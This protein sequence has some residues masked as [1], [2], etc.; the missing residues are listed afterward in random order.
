MDSRK[1]SF[2]Q[3]IVGED[4]AGAL[5][6]ATAQSPD[7]EWAILPRVV[8]AWLEVVS[9]GDFDGFLPGIDDTRLSFKKSENEFSGCINIDGDAYTFRDAS[10]YHIAGSVAVALGSD[11]EHAPPL[12]SPALSKFGKTVDLLVKAR[13]LRKAQ[14]RKGGAGGNAQGPGPAAAP[15]PSDGPA[16]PIPEAPK[17]SGPAVGTKAAVAPKKAATTPSGTAKPVQGAAKQPKK[18]TMKVTKAEARMACPA[19]G[20]AQFKAERYVGCICFKS[21]SKS[22]QTVS[23]A[24]HTGYILT[25][26]S[27][28]DGE[29]ITVLAESMGK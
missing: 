26:G 5:S 7:L 16:A 8:M 28:W 12:T 17:P 2:L 3:A 6:K 1:L 27:D 25:F 24:D 11:K 4:G 13:T 15:R 9:E 19:C 10:L 29:A 20:H 23:T 18:P 14:G 21:L 22:V